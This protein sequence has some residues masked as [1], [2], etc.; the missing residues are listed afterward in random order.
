MVASAGIGVAEKLCAFIMLVP[1]A[2]MQAM[3]AF[4][5]QNIGA[6][7]PDRAKRALAYGIASSVAAGLIMAYISFF[8]GNLLAGLFSRDGAVIAASADYLRAYAIDCIF[9]AFLLLCRIL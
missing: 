4:V 9:T 7:K 8:H 1:S 6:K 3:S 5:A 2:Y